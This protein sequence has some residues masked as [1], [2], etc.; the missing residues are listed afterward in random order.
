[1]PKSPDVWVCY[2]RGSGRGC[3][4]SSFRPM[5]RWH[6]GSGARKLGDLLRAAVVA[7]AQGQRRGQVAD[8]C[9]QARSGRSGPT[10]P[11][12]LI[13]FDHGGGG[14]RLAARPVAEDCGAGGRAA[15]RPR[16]NPKHSSSKDCDGLACIG[17][18]DQPGGACATATAAVG[19]PLGWSPDLGQSP[20][21]VSSVHVVRWRGHRPRS[22]RL[23]NDTGPNRP[24]NKVGT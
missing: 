12:Q 10:L 14:A 20:S 16:G 23:H 24:T 13:P 8:W 5:D 6:D 18:V 3:G 19:S 9:A 7:I 1:M 22:R 2:A 21:R 4:S 17:L 15:A 11:H